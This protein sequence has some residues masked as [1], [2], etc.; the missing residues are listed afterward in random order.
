MKALLAYTDFGFRVLVLIACL[1]FGLIFLFAGARVALAETLRPIVQ[2]S[3]QM[4]YL[5]DLFEGLPE[6]KAKVVLGPAPQPGKEMVLNAATLMR[7]AQAQDLDW[8]PSSTA[9]QITIRRNATVIGK[10]IVEKLINEKLFENGLTGDYKLSMAN[11]IADIVMPDNMPAQAEVSKFT[12]NVQKDTFEATIAAPSA[13][14]PAYE[15]NV[16]GSVDRVI[17]LPILKT[18]LKNG[19]IISDADIDFIEVLQKDVQ[20]D[21]ILRAETLKGM[22][23]R[24]MVMS[25]KPIRDMELENPQI[26]TR[27]ASVTLVYKSGPMT[28]SARG[29]SMQGGARGDMV[30]VI[31]M[32][33]NRSLE[34]IV[35]ADNEVTI[36][37]DTAL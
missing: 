15:M 35:T 26:V 16:S 25:G 14:N 31:N 22:T 3:N 18:S 29:K 27:G 21:Y 11:T 7:V 24:R 19:D 28:L 20:R 33:S 17:S 8:R 13:T 30:R 12:F 32:N 23:P 37:A 9:E 36:N 6:S 10:D 2:I 34:G 4:L 5:G 1:T